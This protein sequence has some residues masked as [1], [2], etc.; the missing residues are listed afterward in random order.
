MAIGVPAIA[1]GEALFKISP[2]R[3]ADNFWRGEREEEEL[4][5][6]VCRIF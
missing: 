1:L 4:I 5:K 6:K 2:T 3:F